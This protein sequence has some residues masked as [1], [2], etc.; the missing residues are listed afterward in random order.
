[1]K[2]YKYFYVLTAVCFLCI[3]AFSFAQ[4]QMELFTYDGSNIVAKSTFISQNS[5]EMNQTPL[6]SY[7]HVF[8]YANDE[9]TN[10]SMTYTIEF[11]G[12]DSDVQTTYYDGIRI[13]NKA[14]KQL[15]LDYQ[16]YNSF[17]DTFFITA[18]QNTHRRFLRIPLGNESF[19]LILGSNIYDDSEEAPE[20]TIVVV[21][22]NQAKVVF[23]R[24]AFVYSYLSDSSNFSMEFV[25]NVTW[26]SSGNDEGS[27]PSAE[28]L[29]SKTKH[30]I[31]KEGNMLKY[32]S[33]K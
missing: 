18:G 22:K 5:V 13:Y 25:E 31:W 17:H 28:P 26:T 14:T 32:K 21:S 12:V 33:W 3:P 1:M 23:D 10:A 16:G 9:V 15:L 2:L 8:T 19:A 6:S 20:L 11:V 30:K 7:G 24:P 29:S 4:S 27:E